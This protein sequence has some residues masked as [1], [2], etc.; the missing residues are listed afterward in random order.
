MQL[1]LFMFHRYCFLYVKLDFQVRCIT[2]DLFSVCGSAHVPA[3]TNL[4]YNNNGKV[5]VLE[6]SPRAGLRAFEKK[7]KK[8]RESVERTIS[9]E[10]GFWAK[11]RE[12]RHQN[13]AGSEKLATK[14]A[15]NTLK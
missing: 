4:P 7:E 15:N 10:G 13:R 12:N 14:S 6:S 2:R 9:Q 3:V 11:K 8:E 5:E 1:S